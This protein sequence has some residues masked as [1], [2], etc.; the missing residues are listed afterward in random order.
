MVLGK[1]AKGIGKAVQGVGEAV[2][3]A[4]K[5]GVGVLTLDGKKIKEGAGK[6]AGG[7]GN[8]LG[9][10]SQAFGALGPLGSVLGLAFPPLA[11]MNLPNLS[12]FQG[13][14]QNLPVGEFAGLVKQALSFPAFADVSEEA[15]DLSFDN[16]AQ[17]VAR[18][19]ASRVIHDGCWR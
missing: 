13:L 9:G 8:I 1:I 5:V 18:E 15:F 14:L 3:G 6:F 7:L 12:L 16:L 17:M 19:H 11:F 10:A 4:L 2:G